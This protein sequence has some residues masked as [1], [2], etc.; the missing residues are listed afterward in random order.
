VFFVAEATYFLLSP[1]GAK[2]SSNVLSFLFWTIEA[3]E[4]KG[5]FFWCSSFHFS[6]FQTQQ[7]SEAWDGLLFRAAERI[8]VIQES[9]IQRRKRNTKKFDI[10]KPSFFF[11]FLHITLLDRQEA[12][13][14]AKTYFTVIEKPP[15]SGDK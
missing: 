13:S 12:A 8:F 14:N 10:H 4:V 3:S 11:V 7:H 9:H 1:H 15:M 5:V 6:L 2:A